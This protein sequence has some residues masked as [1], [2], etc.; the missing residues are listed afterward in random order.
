MIKKVK[1]I[2]TIFTALLLS[3]SLNG[4]GR[5]FAVIIDSPTYGAC[6]SE[7][8][9]YT[10]MLKSEGYTLYLRDADWREPQQVKRELEKLYRDS[11]LRGAIFIGQIPIPM[12]RDAQYLTSAFKMDQRVFPM[13][14]SSVPSDRYYDDF[15]LKFDYLGQD[16]TERLFHYFSL[17]SYS[18][19]R[20]S[21]DIYT[22]RLKPTKEGE[23]GYN[24]IRNYFK[25][26]VSERKV[27][28]RL[29]VITTFTGE[30]SFSNSLT[31][32]K[33]EGVTLREQFPESFRGDG[34]VKLLFYA[35]YPYMKDVV[36]DELRRQES[37][38][39]IFH[40]HGLPERQYMSEHPKSIGS[41]EYIQAAKRI[42]RE[43]LRTKKSESARSEYIKELKERYPLDSTW[44]SG[45]NDKKVIKEDS[46][47]YANT[48]I[49]LSDLPVIAPNSRFVIFDACYN[50]DFREKS[51]IGAEYIFAPGKTVVTFGNSANVLQDK[52]SSDLMGMLSLGFSIGEWAQQ[53]NILESHITGDPTFTFEPVKSVEIDLSSRDSKYWISLLNSSPYADIQG[54]AL[55]RLFDLDYTGLERLLY[56]TYNKSP[57]ATVRLQ[58]YHLLQFYKSPLF[59]QM[60]TRSVNDTYE[61]IRRKSLFS[62]GRIGSPEFI[63][64]I[65]DAYLYD[66]MDERVFFNAMMCFDLYRADDLRRV[67]NSRIAEY[68]S[69]SSIDAIKSQF[70]S[71]LA[72]RA[73]IGKMGEDLLDKS[74]S[75]KARYSSVQ[76]LRNYPYHHLVPE[77]LKVLSD[78]SED[79][80]LRVRLAEALGWFTLSN[81]RDAIVTTCKT[82]ASSTDTPEELKRE[83]LKTVARIDVYMR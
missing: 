18:P 63:P 72:S 44:F 23:E 79:L 70:E 43:R 52:S 39:F 20:I 60:L 5:G 56:D 40:E 75:L 4:A 81:E 7:I 26:L 48:G 59:G 74:K 10:T 82:I 3:A 77:Y 9:A 24:Q 17:N 78:N 64:Y 37:D 69:E 12:V 46:I 13:R 6:K 38:L 71:A 49:D 61:F 42:I 2:S 22:G 55:H 31:A 27:R 68:K 1:I 51:Y 21:C 76:M 47:L 65:I 80:S 14:E 16:S 34:S 54:L 30:G 45:W 32:W 29:N 41:D 33:E 11:N 50:G 58:V 8:E 25:K 83:L 73:S 35:M 36:T 67:F 28:N 53:I 15:D 62:M 66:N 57:Y 19:Q